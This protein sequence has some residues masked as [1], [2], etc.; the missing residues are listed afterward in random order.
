M[1]EYQIRIEPFQY[2]ALQDLTIRHEVN[3]HAQA[4]VAMRIRDKDR[5]RYLSVLAQQTWVKIEGVGEPEEAEEVRMILFY[6]VVTD[7]RFDCDGYETILKL[8]LSSGT[9][10]MDQRTHFRVF[11][12]KDALCSS[13]AE[14]LTASY[15]E[16]RCVC[17]AG[18]DG[19][20]DGVLI[21][22]HESYWEFIRRMEARNGHFLVPDI[23]RKGV[24]Y[25]IGL[26]DGIRREAPTDRF[27][28]RLDVEEYMQKNQ[29]GIDT[30][31]PEDMLELI[32]ED[33][34]VCRIGDSLAYQGREYFAW[35]I[36]TG[37]DGAECMHT[38]YFRTKE[39][40]MTLP[41]THQ[42]AAGCSFDAV[43]TAVKQDKVQLD[44]K[45]DEWQAA[46]GR[47]WFLYSTVYSSADGTGWYCMPEIGDC[48]R[49]YIPEREEDSFVLSAVHKETDTARQD[50][51]RK[52][53]R[54]K[55]GKEILFTP[56]AILLTNNQGMRLEMNDKEGITISSDKDVVIDAKD[57]LT[58]SSANAS[59]MIAAKDKVQVR[60][61][62][63]SMTLDGDIYFTGG[64]FRIQ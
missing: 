1:R 4:S 58:I 9:V 42:E 18:Q 30:L 21:Q 62:S 36:E 38:C 31:K 11:Q 48:V 39:A 22:Y 41:D 6:G 2:T 27:G 37:Y 24:R 55:Y 52:S 33:R 26:P 44:I 57:N 7:F 49:L 43:V 16:G 13:I 56:E 28:F 50:P 12:N 60:Q 25:T 19:R 3:R 23:T 64:E 8:Y 35:R 32:L 20:I 45:G 47:K 29:N 51:D 46:D 15:Q 14:R 34:E 17:A 61:G 54:T 10:L 59:L 63:T 40:L 53:F 5:E